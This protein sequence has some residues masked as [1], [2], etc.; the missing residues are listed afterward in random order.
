[1]S[2]YAI[3][4]GAAFGSKLAIVPLPPMLRS[5]SF[6]GITY[7]TLTLSSILSRLSLSTQDVINITSKFKKSLIDANP[8]S[9]AQALLEA[10]NELRQLVETRGDIELAKLIRIGFV[11]GYGNETS[12]FILSMKPNDQQVGNAATVL[13]RYWGTLSSDLNG[14]KLPDIVKQKLLRLNPEFRTVS[15]LR[16]FRDSCYDCFN[17]CKQTLSV[18]K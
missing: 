16:D 15:D 5:Q 12:A 14:T 3:E 2:M 11:L 8:M 1:M 10:I 18:E 7:D 9:A 13:N 17:A 6:G 4:A